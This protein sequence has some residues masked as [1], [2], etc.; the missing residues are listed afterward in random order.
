[1]ATSSILPKLFALCLFL[2][3]FACRA[4]SSQVDDR[5][6]QLMTDGF[7]WPSTMSLYDEELVEED[8]DTEDGPTTL[9][10]VTKP[11]ALFNPTLEDALELPDAEDKALRLRGH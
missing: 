8:G 7:E 6:I 4:Q 5:S 3:A 11:G 2:I 10:T 1:M 9:T